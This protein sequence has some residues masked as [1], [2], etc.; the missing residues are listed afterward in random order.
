MVSLFEWPA[1]STDPKLHRE[2]SGNDKEE[3]DPKPN[4][5]NE[6]KAAF[7]SFW[8]IFT[9]KQYRR[10]NLSM[11]HLDNYAVIHAFLF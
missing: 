9:S 5:G 7:K 2:Y 4:I 10:Q 1:N 3:V 11:P 6:L 8:A